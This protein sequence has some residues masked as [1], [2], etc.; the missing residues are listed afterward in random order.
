MTSLSNKNKRRG[1]KNTMGKEVPSKI[2]FSEQ[3]DPNTDLN[4]QSQ[5]LIEIPRLIPPSEKQGKGLLPPNVFVTSVD[6]EGGLQTRKGS[7]RSGSAVQKTDQSKMPPVS[8]STEA[9]DR[10]AIEAKWDSLGFVSD[11]TDL[12]TGTIVGWKALG[13]NPAT[14][15]PEEMLHVGTVVNCNEDQVTIKSL[16]WTGSFFGNE[17]D[18]G[19]IEESHAWGNIVGRWRIISV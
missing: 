19:E 2:V 6:V 14:I 17:E 12:P 16:D 11:V 7:D 8:H 5:A 15:T 9:I 18:V 4:D 3:V 13:I 10:A 1:F